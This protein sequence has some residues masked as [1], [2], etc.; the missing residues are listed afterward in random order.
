[1]TPSTHTFVSAL[2]FCTLLFS[3]CQNSENK[4]NTEE[5]QLPT[6]SKTTKST[7]CE[8]NITRERKRITGNSMHPMIKNNERVILLHNYYKICGTVPQKG[9]L[10][11]YDYVGEKIPIIKVLVATSEDFLQIKNNTLWINGSEYKN[12]ANQRYNFS[13]GEI[14]MLQL[15]THNNHLR[16]NTYFIL[17]DNINNSKDSRK[18]G[19]ISPKKILGK[20]ELID[21]YDTL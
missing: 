11:A 10:I 20:F 13:K 8:E 14:Q 19:A 2:F 17:G 16:E 21:N 5:I 7:S 15:Y 12:S 3:G 9:D 1:M 6:P 4:T 18:F